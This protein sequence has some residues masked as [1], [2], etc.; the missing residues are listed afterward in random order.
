M[1]PSDP[2][3]KTVTM[4]LADLSQMKDLSC[5]FV[6]E[7]IACDLFEKCLS[8]FVQDRNIN[9]RIVALDEAHKVPIHAILTL[10]RRKLIS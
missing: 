7:K 1:C 9:G 6:D 2:F 8:I 5:P 3:V 10:N 4:L